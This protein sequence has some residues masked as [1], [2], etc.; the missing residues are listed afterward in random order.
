MVAMPPY[1]VCPHPRATVCGQWGYGRASQPGTPGQ[2]RQH[3]LPQP[4]TFPGFCC[5][6]E[7]L[8]LHCLLYDRTPHLPKALSLPKG[9]LPTPTGNGHV[10]I[11]QPFLFQTAR[12]CRRGGLP[13]LIK[14]ENTGAM[15]THGEGEALAQNIQ[16]LISPSC[17]LKETWDVKGHSQI[18]QICYN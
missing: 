5:R 12:L 1:S 2:I 14:V 10:V 9:S 11:G 15:A 16:P 18:A 7:C 8:A 13:I 6:K 3:P 17:L 4:K